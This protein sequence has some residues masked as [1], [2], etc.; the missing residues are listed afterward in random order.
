MHRV[1]CAVKDS[2]VQDSFFRVSALAA[3]TK[4]RRYAGKK[5]SCPLCLWCEKRN[6]RPS[7]V[8]ELA[9]A[10]RGFGRPCVSTCYVLDV[11][12]DVFGEL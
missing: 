1:F 2:F 10:M 9:V 3:S 5:L 11:L 12:R 7:P 6:D 4:V 8:C